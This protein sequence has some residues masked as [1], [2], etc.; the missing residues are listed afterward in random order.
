M[1]CSTSDLPK[2]CR[3]NCRKEI[4]IMIQDLFPPLTR[5][6]RIVP[7]RTFIDKLGANARMKEHFTS[8]VKCLKET[9]LH[10]VKMIYIDPPYNTGNDFVYEDD[11]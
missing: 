5:V 8:D 4:R 6:N 11:F 3:K 7:K 1:I 10:K 9:Y 2:G